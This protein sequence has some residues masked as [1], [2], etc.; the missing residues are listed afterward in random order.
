MYNRMLGDMVAK[1][2]R[3]IAIHSGAMIY[4]RWLVVGWHRSLYR[5]G[6]IQRRSGGAGSPPRNLDAHREN[7][8]LRPLLN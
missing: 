3:F 6:K 8:G 5:N 7:K 2:C 4:S 1:P